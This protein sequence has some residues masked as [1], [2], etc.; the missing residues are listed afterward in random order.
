ML[1]P[2]MAVMVYFPV[3]FSRGCRSVRVLS[4]LEQKQFQISKVLDCWVR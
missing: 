4:Y 1:E 2:L 3:S